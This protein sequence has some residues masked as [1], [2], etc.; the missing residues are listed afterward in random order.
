MRNLKLF[1]GVLAIFVVAG[2]LAGCEG[3]EN[4][5]RPVSSRNA[6]S[7]I[8][9]VREWID[10]ETGCKYLYNRSSHL[11]NSV[12]GMTIRFNADGTPDCPN[13]KRN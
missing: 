10:P 4:K 1:G 8:G 5:D 11:N 12:G 7:D 13:V 6:D 9:Y 2:F 3:S